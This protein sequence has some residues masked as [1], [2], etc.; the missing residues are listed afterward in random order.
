MVVAGG[1]VRNR[2]WILP[3]HLEAVSA[4]K[5]S[6]LY[7]LTGDNIDDTTGVLRDFAYDAWERGDS[8][9]RIRFDILK[10]GF[11]GYER[12]GNPHRYH[13]SNMAPLRNRW[14]ESAIAIFPDLTHL[15][16]V[17]SDVLPAPDCLEKLLAV[18]QPVVAAFVPLQDG[19]MPIAMRG[20]DG[21]TGRA[22]RVGDEAAFRLPFLCTMVGGCYLIRRDAIDAGL[23]WAPHD[24]G[25]DGGFGDRAREL[26]IELWCEP[27]ARTEH[28]MEKPER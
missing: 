25:E 9:R 15:W 1:I 21:M 28:V 20:W 3:R 22:D 17:D 6:A 12:D 4:N 5:P 16:V 18:D 23:R 19:K 7:Y 10:T 8:E 11:P 26:G 2:A 24:Q 13:S 27:N 14:L